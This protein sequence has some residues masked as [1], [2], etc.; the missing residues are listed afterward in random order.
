MENES[1]KNLQCEDVTSQ[2]E[3]K[4]AS[5]NVHSDEPRVL[6]ECPRWASFIQ[7]YNFQVF[8]K[9]QISYIYLFCVIR[10]KWGAHA[11][12]VGSLLPLWEWNSGHKA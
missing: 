3:E 7:L 10:Q 4:D 2:P 11:M 9:I 6:N 8:N 12:E 5:A 1:F